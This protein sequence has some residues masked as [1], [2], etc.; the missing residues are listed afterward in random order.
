M[1]FSECLHGDGNLPSFGSK[2]TAGLLSGHRLIGGLT[3]SFRPQLLCRPG[4]L[5]LPLAPWVDDRVFLVNFADIS[6]LAVNVIDTKVFN[7]RF[8]VLAPDPRRVAALDLHQA[9][10]I[11]SMTLSNH[12]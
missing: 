3:I 10:R 8:E 12:S 7:I 1:F 4:E 2:H 6:W 11:L 9:W 5:H